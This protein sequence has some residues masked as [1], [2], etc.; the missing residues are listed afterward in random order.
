MQLIDIDHRA[1]RLETEKGA[2]L[3]VDGEPVA[4][5]LGITYYAADRMTPDARI[6]TANFAGSVPLTELTATALR[7]FARAVI[8]Y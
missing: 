5:R 1:H 6:R 8:A 7:I 4:M 3:F 2:V